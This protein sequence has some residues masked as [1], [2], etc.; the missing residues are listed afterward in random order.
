VNLLSVIVTHDRWE[1]SEKTIRSYLDTVGDDPR[2]TQLL[3]VDNFS[4]DGTHDNLS[5][6]CQELNDP[7]WQGYRQTNKNLFPGAATNIGWHTVLEYYPDAELLHRSDND[8][9]YLPGWREEVE[10]TFKRLPHLG[11]LGILNAHE[12]YPDGPPY[13]ERW[14]L[15]LTNPGGNSVIR[16]E[17]YDEGFR[18][19]PG[20]WR[21]GGNDEDT[22]AS[23]EIMSRG[24][25]V[26]RLQPTVANNISFHQFNE[27]PA[28]YR[29]TAMLRGLVP[30]TSV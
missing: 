20:T 28:Y 10:A 18:W 7:R 2:E 21:P 26:G 24:W 8:I 23:T 6:L 11:Q 30:E 27:Y 1:Y 22:Q 14:G 12:D 4:S 16:R 25:M 3:V 15:W 9:E 17:I 5:L 13:E 19:A 29:R